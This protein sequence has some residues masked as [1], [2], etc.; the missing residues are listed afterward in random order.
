MNFGR[1]DL[2]VI[3]YLMIRVRSPD[4]C[5]WRIPVSDSNA[6]SGF[7]SLGIVGWVRSAIV[8]AGTVEQRNRGKYVTALKS[9]PLLPQRT[10]AITYR[11]S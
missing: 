10:R 1:I 9:H 2:V 8:T 5:A 7:R 11:C 3:Q 4:D 6:C